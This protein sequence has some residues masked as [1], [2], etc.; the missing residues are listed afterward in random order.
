MSKRLFQEGV[1]SELFIR[2]IKYKQS[3]CYRY[4]IPVQYTLNKL[5]DRLNEYN[6]EKAI[7]TKEI[8]CSLIELQDNEART[9]QSKR[10]CLLRHFA[11]FLNNIDIDAYVYPTHYKP[12]YYDHFNPY[13]F[14]YSQIRNIFQCSDQIPYNARSPYQHKIWPAII[15]TL[16]GCGLRL[17][18]C[19]SLKKNQVNLTDGVL[20]IEK[21][22]NGTS[23]YVP[24]STSLKDYLNKYITTNYSLL[25][26]SDYIFPSYYSNGPYAPST[27]RVRIKKIFKQAN[28]PYTNNN[29]LPRIHDLRHTFC[30]HALESMEEKGNNLYYSLPI[31]SAYVGHQGIRDTERYL[32]LPE[33]QHH[34]L[35]NAGES[36][37]SVIEI[38]E[39]EYEDQ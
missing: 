26:K 11:E 13:I 8:V 33:F 38:K 23:R 9:T 24:I 37:L 29:R 25:D 4:D 21:S 12:I 30:C 15:R 34:Q 18:E 35:I 31:L 3:L 5:N 28:I 14:T 7:L 20:Y 19:L 1:F 6:L 27:A 16:Y 17:S 2:F 10:I 22:K 32:H 39:A 36:I